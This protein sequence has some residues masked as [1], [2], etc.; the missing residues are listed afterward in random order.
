MNLIRYFLIS[1]LYQYNPTALK[2]LV[3]NSVLIA[4]QYKDGD[5]GFQVHVYGKPYLIGPVNHTDHNVR[6][7]KRLL[8]KLTRG[9]K[10]DILYRVGVVKEYRI[11]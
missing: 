9:K 8:N 10:D 3:P 5:L 1:K 6:H 11:Y 4:R 7:F 2:A